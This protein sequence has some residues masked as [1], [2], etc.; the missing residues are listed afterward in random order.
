[1]GGHTCPGCNRDWECHVGHA[2]DPGVCGSISSPCKDCEPHL[3]VCQ[4]P[5]CY[6][7]VDKRSLQSVL[8]HEHNGA[9]VPVPDI[10]GQPVV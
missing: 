3:M 4:A 1:M 7:W 10:L 2:L 8:K 5:N 6:G 9:V